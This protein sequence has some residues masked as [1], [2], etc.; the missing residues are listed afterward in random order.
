L[1]SHH[2]TQQ[3]ATNRGTLVLIEGCAVQIAALAAL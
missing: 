3:R 1:W 2:V